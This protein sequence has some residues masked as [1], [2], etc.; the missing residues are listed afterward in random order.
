[1]AFLVAEAASAVGTWATI[2]AIWA[3]GAYRFDATAADVARFG[4]AFSVPAILLGPFVGSLIDRLGPKAVLAASKVVGTLAALALLAADDFATL[5][6]LSAMHGVASALG[7][8]AL[9]TM[10]PR[11][12]GEAHL[13][14]TNALVSLTDELAIVLGPVVGGVAIA[15][16]G[17]RGAFLV[18][19]AT[20]AL[21]LVVLPLVR[22]RPAAVDDGAEAATPASFRAAFAGIAYVWTRPRL[23]RL[24]GTVASVH[25]L[26]GVALLS[27]PLYVRD[28][29]G[30]SPDLF[31]ALQTVF[32]ITLVAGGLLVARAGD[33][34][35]SFRFVALGAAASGAA[36]VVY[37]G[38]PFVGV[39][40]TGVVLWG[41]V[42]AVLS[43]PSRT[44][45]QRATPES[46]HGRVLATDFLASSTANLIGVVVAGGLVSWYGVRTTAAVAGVAVVVVAAA[47]WSAEWRAPRDTDGPE[48]AVAPALVPPRP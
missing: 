1:M 29:L 34:L 16:F 28:V 41:A 9:Q 46:H 21:G 32:G 6:A 3:Y 44:L 37:L 12:V 35:A 23:R 11:L 42:T 25:L 18:D 17:F 13:A 10:P 38:T 48:P 19:A 20:F 14:R 30:R 24:V 22:L 5:T 26:Y 27:E 33:R 47:A 39:A 8:P 43:G 36:A 15:L 40:F 31:A 2:I 4:I 45:L 7:I